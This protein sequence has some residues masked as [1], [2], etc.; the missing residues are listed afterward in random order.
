M[1]P[2]AFSSKL[3]QFLQ[4]CQNLDAGLAS[5]NYDIGALHGAFN[6]RLG[7]ADSQDD[8]NI[9]AQALH[10]GSDERRL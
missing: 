8:R 10:L 5:W 9:R 6:E 3:V 4:R 2:A 1:R 7:F